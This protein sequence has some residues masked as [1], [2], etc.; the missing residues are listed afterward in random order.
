MASGRNS[1]S[2]PRRSVAPAED[3]VSTMDRPENVDR[4]LLI[5]L[6]AWRR[7]KLSCG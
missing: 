2:S 1:M 6:G 5:A 7:R 3:A 4:A